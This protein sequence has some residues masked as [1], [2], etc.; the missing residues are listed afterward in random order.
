MRDDMAR[1]LVGRPRRGERLRLKRRKPRGISQ[2][3]ED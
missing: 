2:L 1:L 3:M